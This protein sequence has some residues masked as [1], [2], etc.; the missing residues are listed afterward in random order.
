[1]LTATSQKKKKLNSSYIDRNQK[2]RNSKIWA[3]LKKPTEM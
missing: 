3:K 1:M 2:G